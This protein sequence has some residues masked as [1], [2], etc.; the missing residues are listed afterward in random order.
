MESKIDKVKE[1]LAERLDLP[2]DI[3]LNIPKIVITGDNEI[4]IENHK[5]IISFDSSEIKINSKVG[6]ITLDGVNLEILFIGGNTIT[7][8]GKFKSLIYEGL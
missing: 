7:I 8:S 4:I 2:R 5:G 6:T 1:G 3:V